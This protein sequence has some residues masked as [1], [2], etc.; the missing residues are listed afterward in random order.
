MLE[1]IYA[2]CGL[3]FA[4][5]QFRSDV[6]TPQE[7]TKFFTGSR[8]VLITLPLGYEQA[9]EAGKALRKFR[10]SLG[11]LQFTVIHTST[12][13]TALTEFPHCTVI[14]I[15]PAD[16]TRFGLP[17]KPLLQRIF[18]KQYD[19]ALDFNL[20]FVLHTA[21]ICKASRAKV[22]VNFFDDVNADLFFNVRFKLGAKRS[23][24]SVYD[25][26]AACLS[27]F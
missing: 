4:R 20:D 21:Y 1:K 8:H 7:M 18:T 19:V 27:M 23:T 24:Q 2:Y 14:R 12:R 3:Q 26:C 17:G 9:A 22:R 6:D 11:H 13:A 25:Q 15:D 5:F 10:D 16:I